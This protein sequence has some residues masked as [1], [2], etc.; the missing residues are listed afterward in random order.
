MKNVKSTVIGA[1]SIVI[2][3]SLLSTAISFFGYNKVIDSV[4][5]IQVNKANQ[6]MLQELLKL[7]YQRQQLAN[8]SVTSLTLSGQKEFEASGNSIDKIANNLLDT[9]ITQQDKE[10]V[11]RLISINK[12]YSDIFLN[13]ISP[14]IKKFDNISLAQS[15]AD[16]QKLYDTL[17]KSQ[18]SLRDLV[19]ADLDPRLNTALSDV[20]DIN[21]RLKMINADSKEMDDSLTEVKNLLGDVLMELQDNGTEETVY[22]EKLNKEI[23]ALKQ[24]ITNV[25][26]N[27]QLIL[28]NSDVLAFDRVYN[29]KQVKTQLNQYQILSN[30]LYNSA[31]LNSIVMYSAA[32]YEEDTVAGFNSTKANIDGL[33]KDLSA[34]GLNTED[35]D[36]LKTQL[37]AYY[38]AADKVLDRSAI[39]RR[40]LLVKGSIQLSDLSREFT[41]NL[42]KLRNSFNGYLSE[43]IKT[44]EKIK[45]TII[46][47][48]AAITLFSILV[49]MLIAFVLAKKITN[50]IN[51]LSAIL[52]RVEKGDLTVRADIKAD[53]EIGGLTKKVNSVLEGQQKMVEQF[54]DTT[55]EISNLKQRLTLLVKQNRDSVSKISNY[56]RN[57]IVSEGTHLD[58]ESIITDVK[59]VSM[60]TQKAADDSRKAIEL[61]KS[62]GKAV[63][64]AELV[65]NSVNETV[66]SIS[67]SISKLEAS[68]GKI[69]EI[70]NTITQIASQTNLLA[71]NA[72]IEA[73]RAGQQGKG[74]AVVADEIRKLSNASN[75]SAT[76]IKNQIKEIQSS[77]T[78]AV[79]K[80]NLGVIGVEDGANRIN[81]VK[82][83][84]SEIIESVN[85]VAQAIKESADKAQNHY[86]TTVQFIEAVDNMS[87][88]AV[89]TAV[90]GE[91][92]NDIIEIQTDTLK[93]LDQISI[94]LHEASD[95]LKNIS[96]KVKV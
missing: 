57:P 11:K 37:N 44:S 90:S 16:A 64:D 40:G 58:T 78:Y 92:I 22:K 27:G 6:D 95:D 26:G 21:R 12:E 84:I 30:L 62:R 9:G 51:S 55:H 13:T 61:A 50:P 75:Q 46:W 3:I 83:G 10:M 38:D 39:M 85:L 5:N 81:K 52:S 71:L 72:A 91:S 59:T 67:A 18:V 32:T 86:E 20:V 4:N 94:L 65:I 23:D 87:R 60:Q 47:I 96:E 14:D 82:E 35:M 33:M 28:D 41:D 56:K 36:S 76:E 45:T 69:G 80:M 77:I 74:F 68:S 79:E 2:V 34:A 66:K 54:K 89:E 73:N 15:S 7:S 19:A 42:E 8:D 43:D 63:E 88:S 25:S 17:Y 24:G 49:G 53:G 93:D 1:F 70:T 48:L 29:L 31:Q